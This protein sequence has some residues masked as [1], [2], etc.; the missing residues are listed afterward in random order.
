M[1]HLLL[2]VL[3]AIP[4]CWGIYD[5]ALTHS[6]ASAHPPYITYDERISIAHDGESLLYSS[7]HIDYRDDG[8]ARVADARFDYSPFVTRNLEPGPPELGPY[9]PGRSMWLPPPPGEPTIAALRANGNVTCALEGKERLKSHDV[10]H[11]AFRG[12]NTARAH[13]D[14]LWV[15]VQ[16]HDIWRLKVTGPVTLLA[17]ANSSI[18]LGSYDIEMAYRGPYLVVDHVVWSYRERVYSQNA[19]YTGEYTF[20]DFAFPRALP[21]SYF[22][23]VAQPLEQA[24]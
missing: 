13:L 22:A 5:V 17:D 9:G 21:A 7:A 10:Y 15:D 12:A 1:M 16:S 24:Q 18:G 11:L 19:Y 4:P 2:A 8:I 20:S 6:A 3:A 23:S 14:D